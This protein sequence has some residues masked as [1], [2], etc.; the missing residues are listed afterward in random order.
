LLE[1]QTG[2]K[3]TGR[4]RNGGQQ[5]LT[6]P[7]VSDS[8]PFE[9]DISDEPSDSPPDPVPPDVPGNTPTPKVVSLPRAHVGP[10]AAASTSPGSNARLDNQH[11]GPPARNRAPTSMNGPARTFAGESRGEKPAQWIRDYER[12]GVQAG[13]DEAKLAEVFQLYLE[14]GST[15][16]EWYEALKQADLK[17][18]MKKF[19]EI[20][21]AFLLRWPPPAQVTIS[22]TQRRERVLAKTLPEEQV[23]EVVEDGGY[24][25]GTHMVW[26]EEILRLAT[27]AG[28]ATTMALWPSV[29]NQLPE[30]L[31]EVVED[32]T[33]G[34]WQEFRDDMYKISAD[35]L[36]RR[37]RNI[38]LQAFTE[39]LQAQAAGQYSAAPMPTAPG[40]ES[41]GTGECNRCG[42]RHPGTAQCTTRQVHRLEAERRE[43][44]NN[45]RAANAQATPVH[46]L[47]TEADGAVDAELARA[48]QEWY[49]S[50]YAQGNGVGSV[51]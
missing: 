45:R 27:D 20:K 43:F 16:E 37:R 34:T 26:A 44:C 14:V 28:D 4:K 12:H 19:S 23:G 42:R 3:K 36:R 30:A 50:N 7:Q 46:Y 5:N 39:G 2:R 9:G 17:V 15:A 10:S 40:T 41:F 31:R 1:E 47:G 25:K 18:D 6:E 35:S 29:R 33:Y 38:Q 13:W 8:D 24:T 21:K 49:T 48:F 11:P 22:M 51:H 32:R